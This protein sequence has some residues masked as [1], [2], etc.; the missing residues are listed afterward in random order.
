MVEITPLIRELIIRTE[1]VNDW[2]LLGYNLRVS[3]RDLKRIRHRSDPKDA[4]RAK[5]ELFHKW[6][7]N[8]GASWVKLS[9]ALETLGFRQLAN[10][11]DLEARA[12]KQSQHICHRIV[13][14]SCISIHVIELLI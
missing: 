1:G 4:E 11:I 14:I 13:M 7:K 2:Q 6:L 5:I 10:V 9:A 3:E 8:E 12:G